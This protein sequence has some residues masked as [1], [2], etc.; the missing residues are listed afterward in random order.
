MFLLSVKFCVFF[1]ASGILC[2][3]SFIFVICSRQTPGFV[4]TDIFVLYQASSEPEALGGSLV[5]VSACELN[6]ACRRIL[7]QR[8]C[9]PSHIQTDVF[10]NFSHCPPAGTSFPGFE[11]FKT[12][13]QGLQLIRSCP[14]CGEHPRPVADVD[15]S[16][17][18]CQ[19]FSKDGTRLGKEDHR[20]S[21]LIAWA[22]IHRKQKTKVLIHENVVGFP[23]SLLEELLPEYCI[24]AIKSEPA[25]SGFA[26]V[27]RTRLYHILIRE[28]VQI[29]RDPSTTYKELSAALRSAVGASHDWR[30]IMCD[31]QQKR[32]TGGHCVIL[33]GLI[34][35]FRPEAK[36]KFL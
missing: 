36:N 21:C 14:C 12:H 24:F 4:E 34:R 30:W 16:G 10:S 13:L 6:I 25:D 20:I 3:R 31:S 29:L 22:C 1:P 19:P 32:E 8:A 18:P 2:L 7:Q 23:Q 11:K 35:I 9:A 15:M 17:T 27:R 5:S 33:E 26:C 28:D